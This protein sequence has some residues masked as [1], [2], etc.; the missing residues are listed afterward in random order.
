MARVTHLGDPVLLAASDFSYLVQCIPHT[1]FARDVSV[2]VDNLFTLVPPGLDNRLVHQMPDYGVQ[3]MR[4]QVRKRKRSLKGYSQAYDQLVKDLPS[5][6]AHEQFYQ[7]AQSE[8]SSAEDLLIDAISSAGTQIVK[9]RHET[10]KR[11]VGVPFAGE[12]QGQYEREPK[13]RLYEEIER[14]VEG[15]TSADDPKFV[16]FSDIFNMVRAEALMERLHD[17]DL[18]VATENDYARFIAQH[19]LDQRAHEDTI[20]G[21]MGPHEKLMAIHWQL[22]EKEQ[23]DLEYT[24]SG[25]EINSSV[26]AQDIITARLQSI[27]GGLPLSY[28]GLFTDEI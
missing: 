7:A 9:M 10:L 4:D 19:D 21:Y 18:D 16:V 15:V 20:E 2:T 5:L 22:S 17:E 28:P 26:A 23:T 11:I 6:V 24:F 3:L 8:V 25:E 1:S 13:E 12:L 14:E 27:A